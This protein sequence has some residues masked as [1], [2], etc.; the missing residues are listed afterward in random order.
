MA[1]ISTRKGDDGTTGLLYGQRVEKDHP[2]IEAVGA[3]DDTRIQVFFTGDEERV[4]SPIAV[5]RAEL[6]TRS[7]DTGAPISVSRVR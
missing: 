6:I 4:G 1:S 3:L 5:A 7:A 2:Q